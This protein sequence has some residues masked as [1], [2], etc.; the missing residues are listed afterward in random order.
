MELK[1]ILDCDDVLTKFIDTL[2]KKYNEKYG[3]NF[4]PENDIT[5]WKIDETKFEHGLFK[6]LEENPDIILEMPLKDDKIPKI[7][8]KYTKQ[9]VKFKMVSATEEE[10]TFEKKLE[11]LKKY[12]IDKYFEDCV[13]TNCKHVISAD[14]IVDDYIENLNMYKKYHP[15]A[16]TILLTNAHNRNTDIGVHTRVDNW[17]ELDFCLDEILNYYKNLEE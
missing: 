9:G 14:V 5:E 2:V 16:Y 10:G 8:K 17:E 12:K 11:L 1:V 15:F 4:T 3:T 13:R 7:L 6:L